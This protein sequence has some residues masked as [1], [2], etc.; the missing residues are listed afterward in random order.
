MIFKNRTEAGQKL[1]ALLISYKNQPHTIVLALPRGGL[2]VGYEIAKALKLPLDVFLARKLGVPGN[3]ELAFGAIAFGDAEVLNEDIISQLG[4]PQKAINAVRL[5]ERA[6][7]QKRNELYRQGKPPP[8]LKGKNIL[9]V[10]DGAATGA[11][12]KAV[13]KALYTC[14]CKSIIIALPVAPSETVKQLSREADQVICAAT[15]EPF[16]SIGS[17]YESF[18]QVENETVTKLLEKQH[19][20]TNL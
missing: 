15:P 17:W 6:I 2:P 10:D 12:L 8:S 16:F 4:L 3:E 9:L 11:T 1:A 13:L 19:N 7:L 18:P 20:T 14:S 5:Q